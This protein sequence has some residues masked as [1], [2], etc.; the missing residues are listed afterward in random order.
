[1]YI[2]LDIE[3][4]ILTIPE[5]C[6]LPFSLGVVG[7]QVA[8]RFFWHVSSCEAQIWAQRK[9]TQ[10]SPVRNGSLQKMSLKVSVGGS[11]FPAPKK[12]LTLDLKGWTNSQLADL[13]P[14][15]AGEPRPEGMIA[16]TSFFWRNLKHTHWAIL[17]AMLGDWPLSTDEIRM[18][19]LAE[20]LAHGCKWQV[21]PL[22]LLSFF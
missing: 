17:S 21:K 18:V 13:W 4:G 8:N 16:Q 7:L 20:A 11:N 2:D 14:D 1:M 5:F 3:I 15:V 10:K 6:C 9:K 19:W 22:K 12:K